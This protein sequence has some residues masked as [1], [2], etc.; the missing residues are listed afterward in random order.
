MFGVF[1][2]SIFQILSILSSPLL[3]LIL[4]FL[5]KLLV[6]E[7]IIL[8]VEVEVE[9]YVSLIVEDV[10]GL[11]LVVI[12]SSIEGFSIKIFDF[13]DCDC[14]YLSKSEVISRSGSS[15]K[16][17]GILSFLSSSEIFY[18]H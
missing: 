6:F 11:I 10:D 5:L 8:F 16:I 4:L 2:W 15:G 9:V 14:E 13:I 18:F 12:V 1:S 3:V 17:E 7:I